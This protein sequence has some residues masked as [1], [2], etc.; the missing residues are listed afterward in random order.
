MPVQAQDID[1]AVCI[2]AKY[3][4]V[5]YLFKVIFDWLTF[6]PKKDNGCVLPGKCMVEIDTKEVRGSI[7][8][9]SLD[10]SYSVLWVI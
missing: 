9:I 1:C 6:G 3:L 7:S 10:P 8:L 5:W 4:A 2:E